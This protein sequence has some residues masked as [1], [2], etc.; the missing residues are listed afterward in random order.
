M[1]DHPDFNKISENNFCRL[2]AEAAQASYEQ[3][4]IQSL[5][6]VHIHAT[7]MNNRELVTKVENYIANLSAKR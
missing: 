6:N 7:K 4:D 1:L 5:W 3:K 2:A